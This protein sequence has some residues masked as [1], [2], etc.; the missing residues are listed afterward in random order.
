VLGGASLADALAPIRKAPERSAILLD[1]DGTLAPIVRHAD[2]AHV[3][4]R[5]RRL[6]VDI[7][8][9]Y[10]LVACV[11]GRRA[12]DARRIVSIGS[13]H[14]LGT[15]G[16]ELLRAGWGQPRLEPAVEREAL[17]VAEFGRDQDSPELRK[18]RVR[19]ED[20]GPIAAFH[21]RGAPDEDAARRAVDAVAERAEAEGL[22]VHRGRKVLEVRPPVRMDKGAGIV[23]LLSSEPAVERALYAGDDRTDLD[24]FRGLVEL[25]D[26]GRLAQIVR[27]GVVSDEGPPE[28]AEA[29]DVTVPGIEGVHEL[30][31]AL[32]AED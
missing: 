5:T 12:S 24:A 18:L 14:Y 16:T 11:S 28:I 29:A 20:K 19:R 8:R 1:I 13:I 27:V 22:V 2:E 3:P 17:R 25:R 31:A 7:A 23:S 32:L 21:W 26:A 10:G 9:R 15:H 30:L 4:D 6:L